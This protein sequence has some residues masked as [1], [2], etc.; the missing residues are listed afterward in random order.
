VAAFTAL[1]TGPDKDGGVGFFVSAPF[2]RVTY[3]ILRDPTRPDQVATVARDI[4]GVHGLSPDLRY[5]AVYKEQ[6][7]D[8]PTDAYVA[9]TDGSEVVC[10][11]DA[12]V[13]SMPAGPPFSPDGSLVLWTEKV[14]LSKGLGG[15]GWAAS[16]DGCANRRKWG[17]AVVNWL[18]HG[19]TG[20]V[21]TVGSDV[22]PVQIDTAPISGGVDIGASA[23]VAGPVLRWGLV[24]PPDGVIYN[25]SGVS[26]AADGLTYQTLPF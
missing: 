18:F 10:A 11:L 19:T 25:L 26:T 4:S 7:F 20:L 14:D 2:G 23:V 9:R 12:L 13:T 15:E 21:F 8:G 17:D 16:P 24:P 6:S 22:R 1:S 3:E 5:A